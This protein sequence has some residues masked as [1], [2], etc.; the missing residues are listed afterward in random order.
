MTF[1]E[2]AET[3]DSQLI[4]GLL[5]GD[6]AAF[7]TLVSRYH[8]ALVRVAQFYVGERTLAEEAAQ[9]AW[10]G[11]LRGLP[12]FEARASLKTWIF[13]ILINKAKTYA[14]REDRYNRLESL[15]GL[16]ESPAVSPERFASPDPGRS[17]GHWIQRPHNWDDLPEKRL[18]SRETLT[19]IQAAIDRL[20]PNQREVIVLRDVEGWESDEVCNVLAISATNQRVLLHRARAKVREALDNYLQT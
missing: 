15:D 11:V 4:D 20:P 7:E 10:M 6:E 14:R 5:K 19:V 1:L 2:T 9:E 18:L 3:P 17:P 8:G 16:D 12:R 13:S